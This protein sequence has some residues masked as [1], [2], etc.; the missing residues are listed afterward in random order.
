MT[1]SVVN[2]SV[3]KGFSKKQKQFRPNFI[4]WYKQL[5]IVLSVKDNLNYLENPILDAPVPAQ[6]GQQGAQE[7]LTAH[8]AWVNGSKEI[9]RLMLMTMDSKIQRNLENLDHWKRNNPQYLAELLKNKEL[10]QGTCGSDNSIQVSRNNMVYF[11]AILRDGIFEIYLSDSYT[12][13]SSI[14]ALSNKRA[15]SNLD[16]VLLWHCHLGHISKKHI[17]KL[18]HDGLLNSTDLMYFE[19][20]IPCMSGKMTRKPYTRQVERAKDLL[21]LVHRYRMCL[22]IDAE[23]HELGVLGEPANYKAALLDPESDK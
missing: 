17:K 7:A 23:E 22:Y 11:S 16:S 4:D 20:S 13:V 1:T 2:N 8:V 21:G 5:R 18:Q 10:S 14:Y 15:K 6:A 12:N 9:V 19:K 3:F